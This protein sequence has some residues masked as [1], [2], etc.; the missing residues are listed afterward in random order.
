[1]KTGSGIIAAAAN[2]HVWDTVLINYA[3]STMLTD[4]LLTITTQAAEQA[5]LPFR[6]LT[7]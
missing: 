5:K 3:S 4:R 1:M 7:S 6:D 2:L